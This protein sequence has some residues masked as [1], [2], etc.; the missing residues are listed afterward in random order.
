ML[1]P[2]KKSALVRLSDTLKIGLD[3]CAN[4]SREILDLLAPYEPIFRKA[5]SIAAQAHRR[6][7]VTTELENHL[8]R[9]LAAVPEEAS[10]KGVRL[11]G[12]LHS[13]A[14]STILSSCFCLESYISSLAYFLFEETDFLGLIKDGHKVSADLLLEGIERMTTRKKWETVGR[15]R[16]GV[17]LDRSRP[18]FQDFQILFNF[19]DDHVHDKVVDY[20]DDRPTKQYNGKLPDPVTGLLDLGHALY[21]VH[22]YWDMVKETHK[23]IDVDQKSFHRHYNLAPWTDDGHRQELEELA[24][25]YRQKFPPRGATWPHNGLSGN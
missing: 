15:L 25:Q 19:R 12:E 11:Q 2:E 5:Q 14:L 9:I 4:T 6:D 8:R 18:P 7:A 1:F 17:G 23:L 24:A 3:A 21:C 13:Q 10:R 22:T 20:S 16:G